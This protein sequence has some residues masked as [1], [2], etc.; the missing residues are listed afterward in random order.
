MRPKICETR[1]FPEFSESEQDHRQT[2]DE[3]RDDRDDLDEREPELKLSE[4]T[5][6][7]EIHAVQ[8]K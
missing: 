4:E 8:N 5:Y 3:Q 1:G 2:N 6:G 7:D